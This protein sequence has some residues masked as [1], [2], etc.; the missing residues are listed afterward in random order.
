MRA[1]WVAA[2]V[3]LVGIGV[4]AGAFGLHLLTRGGY[5]S[6]APHFV[7]SLFVAGAALAL[8]TAAILGF[9]ARRH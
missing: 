1:L 5:E 2:A 3:V 4:P 8:L 6:A 7:G 9:V